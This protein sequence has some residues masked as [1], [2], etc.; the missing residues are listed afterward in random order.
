MIKIN[1]A[2]LIPELQ[3]GGA[4]RVASIVGNYYV[5]QGHDVYYFLS[6]NCGHCVYE[7]KGKIIRTEIRHGSKNIKSLVKAAMIMRKYKK[8]YHIDVSISFME[9]F[10]YINILSKKQDLVITRICTI[11]SQRNDFADSYL[12]KKRIIN[13]FYNHADYVVV[14]SNYAKNEMVDY[15][16]I[17]KKRIVRIPNPIIP[18]TFIEDNELWTYG[19][20]VVVCVGRLDNIKQQNIAIRVFSKVVAKVPDAKLVIVGEGYNHNKLQ[21]MIN[22]MNLENN[23]IL[24][25]FQN[26]VNYY[27]RHSNVF[28]MTSKTEGFPNSMVEAMMN[29]VPIV[30]I[31]SPGAIKEILGVNSQQI[32]D[33]VYGK[34]GIVTPYINN[35]YGAKELLTEEEE[36]LG[37]AIIEIL[38]NEQVRKKYAIRAYNR[39]KKYE[40]NKV[41]RIWDKLLLG[42]SIR[43]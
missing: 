37:D 24:A 11:L 30:S 18:I 27:L 6:N 2:I 17:N 26:N 10:N 29:K 7:V 3:G 4:E 42:R 9:E 32:N 43:R 35:Q 28:L 25:G 15:Y 21:K 20:N 34:Y 23:I 1:I 5:M 40:I 12:Y 41:M 19:E 22:D 33:I 38:L 8:K 39:V 13:F 31:D 36:K 14:M 16:K